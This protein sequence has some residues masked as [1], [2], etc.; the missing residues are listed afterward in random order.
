M[1]KGVSAG[2]HSWCRWA[3][4]PGGLCISALP[5]PEFRSV[6]QPQPMQMT[7]GRLV[8]YKLLGST[9]WLGHRLGRVM[10][11][12]ETLTL[13]GRANWSIGTAHP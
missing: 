8:G 3:Y 1:D 4:L 10:L 12:R 9:M 7:G 6:A 2:F 13:G 5:R 11:A